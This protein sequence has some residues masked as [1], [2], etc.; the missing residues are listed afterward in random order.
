MTINRMVVGILVVWHCGAVPALAGAHAL[1]SAQKDVATEK[2]AD[3]VTITGCVIGSRFKPS[4]DSLNDLPASVLGASE[5]VLSGKKELLQQI[6]RDHDGHLEEVTGVIK[7]PQGPDQTTGQVRSKDVGKTR[8]TI[9]QRES[10]G[11]IK[12]TP[13]PITIRVD[14]F[15]HLETRCTPK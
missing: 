14:S 13:Q 1:A 10:T 5:W 15:R 2:A 12:E 11:W 8:V 3:L 9:G 7:I 6:R 4:R